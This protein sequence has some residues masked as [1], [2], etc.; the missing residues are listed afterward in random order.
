MKM[1]K[2][3]V[4]VASIVA[5]TIIGAGISGPTASAAP[6]VKSNSN[7]TAYYFNLESI[8]H[9][10]KKYGIDLNNLTFNGIT[11]KLPV[12]G[13]IV[14]K[15]V[16][17]KPTPVAPTPTP[18]TPKPTPEAPTPTPVTPKPTPVAPTPTPVTPKPTPA[19]A[20]PAP[21]TKPDAALGAFQSQVI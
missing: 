14:V 4:G 7:M 10:A 11:I 8:N 12:S 6:V 1:Q 15:P 13:G 2:I 17:P 21:T 20:T 5:A 9:F 16:A 19:P 18:V 3:R